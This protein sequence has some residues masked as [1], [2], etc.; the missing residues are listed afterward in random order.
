MTQCF[1]YFVV[2]FCM[3]PG[4]DDSKTDL[5]DG[6]YN[7]VSSRNENQNWISPKWRGMMIVKDGRY[8]R[9]YQEV[10]PRSEISFHCNSGSFLYAGKQLKMNIQFSNYLFSKI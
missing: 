6:V 8:S 7:L 1:L 5:L 2:L 4:Q 10:E 3:T 9:V